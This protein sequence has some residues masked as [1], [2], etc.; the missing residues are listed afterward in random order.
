MVGE[1]EVVFGSVSTLACCGCSITSKINASTTATIRFDKSDFL[2]IG[3]IN[4]LDEVVINSVGQKR[5]LYRG[6]IVSIKSEP[7][8]QIVIQLDNGLELTETRVR[9]LTVGVDHQE[10]VYSMSRLA[11]FR[12]DSLF[13]H[14]LDNSNKEMLAFVPF[15]G[16][17]IE[18]DETVSGV[19]LLALKSVKQ[20]QER[21]SKNEK[22]ELWHDFLDADGWISFPLTATHFADAEKIA[23]EKVDV[24]LSAYSSLLQ[25][26]YSQFGGDFI[27]WER[28]DGAINLKRQTFMLLVILRTGGAWLRDISSYKPTQTA[29]NP[30]I[31]LDIASVIDA[32]ENFQ[33]PLLVWNRFR[34]SED[35]YLVTLGLWQVVEL[36]ST[37]VQLPKSYSQEQLADIMSRALANLTDQQEIALVRGAIKRLNDG[38]L[39][40]RFIQHLKNIGIVLST[41]EHD[42]LKKFRRIR[43]DIEHGKNAEEPS[44]QEIKQVKALVNRVILASLTLDKGNNNTP[45][46]SS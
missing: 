30:T 9:F 43:N 8:N 36:L 12:H 24:F 25:Y 22:T 35:Y 27:E 44:L 16:L 39:L 11:G 2:N 33:L 32:S 17:V 19:Q 26:S 46:L 42:L 18:R 31:K 41:Y 5:L 23:I 34:D 38:A 10:V 45:G 1:L 4:Y 15:K 14:E 28:I 21:L 7:N 40:E 13:I 3:A 20:I 29:L 37:G 6:N